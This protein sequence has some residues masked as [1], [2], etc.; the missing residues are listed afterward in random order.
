MAEYHWKKEYDA[1][2]K[3]CREARMSF[4]DTAATI[5]GKFGTYFSRNACIGRAL[6]LGL[7]APPKPKREEKPSRSTSISAVSDKGSNAPLKA[8]AKRVTHA[9]EFEAEKVKRPLVRK[10]DDRPVRCDEV[11]DA[12]HLPLDDLQPHS[13]RWPYGGWPDAAPITFCGHP[14]AAGAS[15]CHQH[16]QLSVGVGT[17]AERR[18]DQAA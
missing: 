13:C 1:E 9:V 14:K 8:I 6:R 7:N 18:A 11:R 3:L 4:R 10:L 5:N 12:L 17:L 16:Q 15:Y 2:L